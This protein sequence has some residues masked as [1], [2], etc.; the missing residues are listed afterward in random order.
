MMRMIPARPS[1]VPAKMSQPEP[2]SSESYR[3]VVIGT[4]V[5]GAV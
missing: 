1:I 5:M 2:S 4:S 3:V